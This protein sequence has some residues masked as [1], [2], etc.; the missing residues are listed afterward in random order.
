M[1]E[2][3]EKVDFWK[4]LETIGVAVIVSGIACFGDRGAQHVAKFEPAPVLR[5]KAPGAK[6]RHW[7]GEG[8][9]VVVGAGAEFSHWRRVFFFYTGIMCRLIRKILVFTGLAGITASAQNIG[10]G[11]RG[12]VPLSDFL[13]AESKT[14][15]LTNVVRG[16]GNVILGPMFEVRLPFGLG[17]EANAI[18]RRWNADGALSRGS[19][20]TWEFPVYGKVRMPG[21]VV[22][23]YF[24][25]GLNFQKL[26]DVSR[27]LGAGVIADSSRRGFLGAGGVE[28]KV[29]YVRISPELRFT[30][31]GNSGPLRTTNQIDL[32]VGLSF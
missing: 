2:E 1:A 32:L 8:H 31:W 11:V 25:G 16:R 12:G 7:K 15:A 3:L 22:R 26:G 13:K 4:L 9:K 30:R 10:Y 29:P 27:F 17:I 14:G 20:N 24:G 23:P 5:R 21:I 28:I 19:A 18:Y 6:P